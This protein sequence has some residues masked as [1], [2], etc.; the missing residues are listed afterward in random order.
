MLLLLWYYDEDRCVFLG[1]VIIG[2]TISM[3]V[4]LVINTIIVGV[5]VAS[6]MFNFL[7]TECWDREI[8]VCISPVDVDL[9]IS[10]IIIGVLIGGDFVV[11]IVVVVENREVKIVVIIYII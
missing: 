5:C 8:T 2:V 3:V 4:V 9:R 7:I 6:Y 11:S 1:S 10:C